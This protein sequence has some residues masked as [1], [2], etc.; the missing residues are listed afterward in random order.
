MANNEWYVKLKADPERYKAYQE[1]QKEYRAKIKADPERYKAQSKRR[2]EIHDSKKDE[3]DKRF[4][5]N[6]L[7]IIA[8][9]LRDEHKK[10][11]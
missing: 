11:Y 7:I 1:K 10:I 2:K 3:R 8:D 5:K 9:R 6:R 4:E